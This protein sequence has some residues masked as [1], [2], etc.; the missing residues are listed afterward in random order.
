MDSTT[1][2]YNIPYIST[3]TVYAD[4]LPQNMNDAVNML[5]RGMRASLHEQVYFST[6]A[7]IQKGMWRIQ[8]NALAELDEGGR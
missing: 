8:M 5:D 7:K 3:I 6:Q 2:T 4:S 1:V